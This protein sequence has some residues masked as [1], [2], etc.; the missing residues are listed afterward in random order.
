VTARSDFVRV[1]R[2][3]QHTTRRRAMLQAHPEIR[4]LAGPVPTS[5]AWVVGLVAA[6]FL[7]GF[8]VAD[9]PWWI[10]LPVAYV[11]GATIDHAMWVL[12]HECTH[13]LVFRRPNLNR[14]V[15]IIANLPLVFPAAL[16]FSKYHLLHHQHLG[17]L[18][19]DADLPGPYETR[20]VR[21][22][23][24]KTVWL[25][26]FSAVQGLMRT[27]RLKAVAFFDGWIVTNIVIQ[28]AAMAVLVWLRAWMPL[29][30]L[31]ASSV[32]AVGLHPLGARWIQE[33][34][35][36]REDQETYSYYGPLNRLSFNIGYH[37]EHHDFIN[38]PW[39]RLPALKSVAPE[40]YD[41]LYA[42]HSW[43]RVLVQFLFNSERSLFDRVVRPSRNP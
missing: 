32:F 31:L 26:S 12:I 1:S 8:A 33:H 38:I 13:A 15:A 10:W 7:L 40:F 11:V 29:T 37:N 19:Y 43:T 23:A 16:S 35:V 30:Y 25:A 22:S 20:V 18:E 39:S 6:Q 2:E 36:F 42:H 28:V 17:E 41:S 3:Q 24:L 4:D 9:R 34:Y 14:V 21:G 27:Q 5:A